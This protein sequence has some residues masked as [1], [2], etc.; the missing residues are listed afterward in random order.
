M[1]L[2]RRVVSCRHKL[3]IQEIDLEIPF[4]TLELACLNGKFF[5]PDGRLSSL[6]VD[7]VIPRVFPFSSSFKLHGLC[8]TIPWEPLALLVVSLALVNGF[9][10]W[11][12]IKRFSIMLD[13]ST[14]IHMLGFVLWS[15]GFKTPNSNYTCLG[16][17]DLFY[18]YM[19]HWWMV[20]TIPESSWMV[21]TIPL[22]SSWSH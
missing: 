10:H 19:T 3:I 5:A 2:L 22:S 11:P 16:C 4:G 13:L 20:A 18:D 17:M 8:W 9:H 12:V 21:A 1:A 14:S 7:W 6:V 15:D